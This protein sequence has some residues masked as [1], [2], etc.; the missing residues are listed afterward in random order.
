MRCKTYVIIVEANYSRF[1]S[2][3]RQVFDL[4]EFFR[5]YFRLFTMSKAQKII[6]NNLLT[7]LT[8]IAVVGGTVVGIILR[9][10][11]KTP[12]SPRNTMY[13]QYPGELFLRMLKSLIIPLLVRKILRP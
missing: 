9:S 10:T 11:T 2:F 13:L 6:K 12:W 7:I 5:F 8:V 4:H 3:G 1:S